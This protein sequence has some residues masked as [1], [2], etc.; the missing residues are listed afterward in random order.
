MMSSRMLRYPAE[1]VHAASRARQAQPEACRLVTERKILKKNGDTR[2][3]KHVSMKPFQ[4]GQG[5]LDTLSV[6]AVAP[7][8]V[9]RYIQ[10]Q[11]RA[12]WTQFNAPSD[13]HSF[14]FMHRSSKELTL[15]PVLC[16]LRPSMQRRS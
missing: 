5:S 8:H 11:P 1:A 7:P 3:M 4:P 9:A 12:Q 6:L 16:R 14:Q 13:V 15:T 2:S 10:T